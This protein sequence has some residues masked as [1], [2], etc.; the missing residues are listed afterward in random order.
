MVGL[1]TFS[2]LS[3]FFS[4]RFEGHQWYW[5]IQEAGVVEKDILENYGTVVRWNGPFGVCSA[6]HRESLHC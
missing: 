1:E 5:Q 6:A 2:Y 3:S 4:L